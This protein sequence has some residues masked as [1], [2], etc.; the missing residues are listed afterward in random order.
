[1]TWTDVASC[2][3]GFT[4]GG[5]AW[6]T[7]TKQG[8]HQGG[9]GNALLTLRY[10]DAH[11]HPQQR[12]LFVKEIRD[13]HLREAARYPYLAD[14]GVP[15]ARLLATVDHADAEVIM[16]EFLPTI[17]IGR[18]EADDMLTLA[19]MLNALTDIPQELF[20]TQPG[21]PQDEFDTLVAEA[22]ARLTD[23]YPAVQPTGWLDA[24][25]RAVE[26]YHGLP[27][28]LTH[29]EFAPQQL[30]R[31][32]GGQ[33]VLFD[34]ATAA[35]RPRFADVA[36]VLRPLS[37]YTGRSE[38]DLFATYLHLLEISGG[39][40]LDVPSA[41]PELLLTRLVVMF[42]SLPWLTSDDEHEP[43]A[44]GVV[45]TIADDLATLNIDVHAR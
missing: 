20:I 12:T 9:P 4:S 3:P 18:D 35:E 6:L 27:R 24:Y 5:S 26:S 41:W 10:R 19:A 32:H 29:G 2:L 11:D 22:L 15:V 33:L 25:R 34:L 38:P 1:M 44:R 17:G 37:G 13:P 21:M 14:R 36:N 28:A 30:G 40:K 8:L 45:H 39:K 16:L 43:S 23:S 31:T 42:E 7:Y